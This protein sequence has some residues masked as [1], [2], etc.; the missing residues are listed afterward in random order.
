VSDQRET[1]SKSVAAAHLCELRE[2][3]TEVEN[4]RASLRATNDKPQRGRTVRYFQILSFACLPLAISAASCSSDSNP[5]T[6]PGCNNFNYATYMPAS[7]SLTLANDIM[8]IFAAN[9]ALATA[10][11]SKG[12]A[13]PPVL[14]D[15]PGMMTTTAADVSA[16]IVGVKSVEVPAL[17]FV[18]AGDPQ[19]S[20]LMRKVESDNPGC[21]LACTSTPPAGCMTR[22]PNGAT[23]LSAADQGK[24]RDWIKAGAH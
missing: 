9:C 7:T 5:P 13:M 2:K 12:T 11:H 3:A 20:Y 10:C 16:A 6:T 23:P 4:G 19:N 14:G 1:M 18:T 17:N 24:I 22:M 8:P 15:V 21:G